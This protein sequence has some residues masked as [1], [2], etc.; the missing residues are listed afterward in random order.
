MDDG[1]ESAKSAPTGVP[2]LERTIDIPTKDGKTTSFI[3]HPERGGP[4]PVIFFYMDAPAIREEL[5]DMAR[6]F[7]SAGYYVLLPNLYYRSGE[8]ELGPLSPDPKA[9]VRQKMMALM[10]SLTIPMIMDD[11][12]ALLKFV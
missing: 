5:R 11:T 2:M 8:M 1:L 10:S 9:P 4:H 12:A 3:V 7:A 6:R